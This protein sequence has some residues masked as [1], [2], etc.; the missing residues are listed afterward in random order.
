MLTQNNNKGNIATIIPGGF[1][2]DYQPVIATPETQLREAMQADGIDCTGLGTIQA[3]GSIHRFPTNEHS[4]DDAGWYVLHA[5]GDVHH[6]AYGD[7]RSGANASFVADIGRPI[8][9]QDHALIEKSKIKRKEQQRQEHAQ[10]A[11]VA[12]QRF[13]EAQ[14]A[15]GEHPYLKRKNIK[16]HGARVDSRG[17]LIIRICDAAGEIQSLQIIDPEAP[18]KE[19]KKN[20][21]KAKARGGRCTFGAPKPGERIYI[22]EGFATA[23][24]IY[25][26]TG[27]P[28]VAAFSSINLLDV[29]SSLV[30]RFAVTVVPDNDDAGHSAGDKCS[31][32]AQH[33]IYP[34]VGDANDY[35]QAGGDLVELLTLK[36]SRFKIYAA[37]GER[38]ADIP[39]RTWFVD[40][41][42]THGLG[43]LSAKKGIGKSM[44][45]LQMAYAVASGSDFLGRATKTG[46]VLYVP[47]ELDRIAMHERL[48]M[49]GPAP[50][51]LDLHYGWTSG[52][53]GIADAEEVISSGGYSMLIIDMFSAVLP[54]DAATNSYDLTPF[55]L[56]WRQMAHRS[57]AAVIAVWHSGKSA[58]ADPMDSAIGTTGLVGQSD[59][60]LTLTRDR[61]S[62]AAKLF[63]GGNHGRES[64]E[65]VSF[66]F[67]YWEGGGTELEL[68][69]PSDA[70]AKTLEVLR[71]NG[72]MTVAQVADSFGETSEEEKAKVR[73]SLHRLKSKGFAGKEGRYLWFSL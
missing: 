4:S 46:K 38:T 25:E 54:T 33:V 28:T 31:A 36:K 51:G 64:L 53:E 43:L 65:S 8:T 9:I 7:W 56:S 37:E 42:I 6:G 2:A 72:P 41:L 39:Q 18:K 23:A 20:L 47:T 34:P 70:D 27:T 1:N 5:D 63:V 55:L 62:P 17:R 16:A 30:D 69:K 50:D 60:I 40:G 21:Y 49:F 68:N 45:A 26:A 15:D 73:T 12:R 13:D 32:L 57:G 3:D 52:A 19:Q 71:D 35:K 24:T 14:P 11:A 22:A 44:F 66:D 10:A 67:P 59:Y 48:E 58:R 29:T 61:G